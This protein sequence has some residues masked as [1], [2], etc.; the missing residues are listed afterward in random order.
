MV[1]G[2]HA[3]A[4]FIHLA[5]HFGRSFVGERRGE[6]ESCVAVMEKR[7]TTGKGGGCCCCFRRITTIG[8]RE[9]QEREEKNEEEGVGDYCERME[10]NECVCFIVDDRSSDAVEKMNGGGWRGYFA[11]F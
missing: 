11:V 7:R 3:L 1:R 8:D 9:V 4:I 6:V 10:I 2:V 5:H